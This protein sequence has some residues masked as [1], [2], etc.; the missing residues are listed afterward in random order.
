[1]TTFRVP[2]SGP[3]VVLP[4]TPGF[5]P[6]QIGR[7]SAGQGIPT[8]T[9]P[10]NVSFN[11]LGNIAPLNFA[12]PAG[13]AFTDFVIPVAGTYDIDWSCNLFNTGPNQV[14]TI[15]WRITINTG[16]TEIAV[17]TRSG[18]AMNMGDTQGEALSVSVD[19]PAG[20]V[21]NCQVDP[22]GIPGTTVSTLGEVWFAIARRVT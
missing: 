5:V 17:V 21:V 13:P 20:N 7:A 4:P 10:V 18:L 16:A 1:M 6:N 8:N 14:I 12:V 19:L 15:T 11:N 9:G 22:F 2:P 3:F